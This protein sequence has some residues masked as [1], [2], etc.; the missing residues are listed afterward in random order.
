MR[1]EEALD[2]NPE[3][4]V[5][6]WR[7]VRA[8]KRAGDVAGN[9]G[10]GGYRTITVDYRQYYAHHLAI[11][12]STG[13]FPPK[14][15]HV[16]HINGDPADNRISNLR[17]TTPSVNGLNRRGLNKNNTTGFRGVY[18]R[19]DKKR[20][21]AC[22]HVNGRKRKLGRFTSIEAAAEAVRAALDRQ[23]REGSSL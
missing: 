8:N 12:F 21:E 19:K 2:Y 16:D 5:F 20:F 9:V 15:S 3:T 23:S 17:I 14:G 10:P 11:F 22:I 7:L 4:G 6:L 18:W 13:E 1:L